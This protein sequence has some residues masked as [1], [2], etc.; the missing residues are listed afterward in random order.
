MPTGLRK[1]LCLSVLLGL[2]APWASAQLWRGPAAIEVK[3]EDPKGKAVAA[4]VRLQCLDVDPPGGPAPVQMDAKGRAVVG[5]LAEGN[6]RLEV[7]RDGFMTYQADI[8]VRRDGKPELLS[9]AQHNVPNAVNTLRVRLGKARGGDAPPPP[10][11]AETA[12]T[13]PPAPAPAPKPAPAPAPVAPAPKPQPA[14]TAPPVTAAPPPPAPV[15]QPNPA[16]T[17]SPAPVPAP[18]P[19]PTAPPQAS[20]PAPAPAP[21]ASPA[22]PSVRRRSF[23]DKSCFE[24]KPGE[25][26]ITVEQ[27]VPAGSAPCGSGLR[28]ALDSGAFTGLPAS[29]GVV[30]ASLPAGVRYVGYRF[31]VQDGAEGFD[32]LTGKEC[33]PGGQWPLD[34]VVRR[35]ESGTGVLAAFENRGSRERRAVLTV[36]YSTRK[37]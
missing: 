36:Y 21:P 17:P 23:E 24:C 25:A 28:G 7:S 3:A 11:V 34:P 33:V 2:V 13:P 19:A 37:K 22:P 15:P 4:E 10:A 9:A 1:I 8:V 29:C 16:P 27:S 35:A 12:P 5:G 18:Q 20:P 30:Q 32:C 31:E 26:S 14:P 6:W